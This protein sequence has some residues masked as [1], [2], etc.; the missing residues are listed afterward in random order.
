[1]QYVHF[2]RK[3]FKNNFCLELIFKILTVTRKVLNFLL[4]L[5]TP[6]DSDDMSTIRKATHL[7]RYNPRKK[8][9]IDGSDPENVLQ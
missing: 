4:L 8:S 3:I 2:L 1:M 9:I 6:Q 5:S 7:E